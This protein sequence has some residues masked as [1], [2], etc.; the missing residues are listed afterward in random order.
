ME[1]DVRNFQCAQSFALIDVQTFTQGRLIRPEHDTPRGSK[2][3]S[4]KSCSSIDRKDLH[5]FFQ[6]I[7]YSVDVNAFSHSPSH[8]DFSEFGVPSQEWLN[9]VKTNPL[10]ARDGFVDNEISKAEQLR[11]S[12]NKARGSASAKLIA[13]TGVDQRITTTTL[14]LPSRAGNTVPLRIYTPRKPKAGQITGAVLYFHGGGFLLGDETSD[15]FLC[16]RMA[17]ETSTVILS[18]IYRH[19]HK[20]PHPAQVEDAWT[21]F[22]YIRDNANSIE[23]CISKGLAVMGISAGCTLAATIMLKDLEWSRSDPGHTSIITGALFGI[24]W[25]IHIDNYPFHLFRSREVSAKIQNRDAPVIPA[26][27]LQLFS[28]LLRADKT[29]RLLNIPLLTNDELEGWP[30]TAF[31]IAG[32]DPLRDDGLIF[33]QRLKK[34]G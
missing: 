8:M 28:D 12:S 18:V 25:L 3:R 7:A 1:I 27:R 6:S 19:T 17:D 15:D 30:K 9:F 2:G 24:P 34:L 22:E 16:C 13:S 32:A 33:A 10:A 29:D 26:E 31:L 21:A 20:H 11:Y 4:I 5:S 23:P 14:Q